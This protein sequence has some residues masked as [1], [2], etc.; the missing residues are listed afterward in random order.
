MKGK[1]DMKTI[2]VTGAAGYIGRHVVE[3]LVT[4]GAHVIALDVNK[5]VSSEHVESIV[6]DIFSQDFDV[7]SIISGEMPDA[8]LHL[9]W[10][11]GFQHN[12]DTHILDLSS[13]YRF[14]TSLVDAG[15]SHIAVMGTMHEVGYWEGA[16]DETTPCNPQ[17]K[18]GIAKDA[19]RRALLLD[20]QSRNYCLQ[21]LRGYY[22]YGDDEKSQS[23]FGKLLGAAH[24][25]KETFPFTSGVNRYDFTD[26]RVLADMISEAVLQTD[27]DGVINC[28]TGNPVSLANKM[29]S[30]IKDNGLSIRL[31]YGAYPDRP[32]DSPGVWGDPD[33]IN[34]IMAARCN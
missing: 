7:R 21:W 23:V 10:R 4:K 30:F 29:E 15:I 3:A 6:G 16:I 24:E 28:C 25:G 19:L 2:M 31:E 9:A 13:H 8:C 18:Y 5:S 14:I 32:Y 33:K 26:I 34:L 1:R 12:A 20:S 11:N 17:S 27:I 22:I